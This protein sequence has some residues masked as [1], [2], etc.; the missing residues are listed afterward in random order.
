MSIIFPKIITGAANRSYPLMSRAV[1]SDSVEQ[2]YRKGLNG[3][4]PYANRGERYINSLL[5]KYRVDSAKALPFNID[6]LTLQFN[7]DYRTMA[8]NH[9]FKEIENTFAQQ[10]QFLRLSGIFDP[11][12]SAKRLSMALAGSDF[13]HHDDFFKQAQTYRNQLIKKLN[14]QLA[15]HGKG[16]KG[17]YIVG[18]IYFGQLKDFRYQLPSLDRVLQLEKIAILSLTGWI[19]MLILL[20][21]FIAS[22]SLAL[23]DAAV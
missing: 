12:L 11:F 14:M 5:K 1:F 23:N 16:V 20:L 6:G 10:Q 7:E 8:F 15:M 17:E 19:I 22:R 4:D 9:Y 2:A 18:P 3:K 13:Y 21:Q